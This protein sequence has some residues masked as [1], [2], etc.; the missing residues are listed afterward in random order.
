M[1]STS[2]FQICTNI[3]F[4]KYRNKWKCGRTW[5]DCLD[6]TAE[7]SLKVKKKYLE[8]LYEWEVDAF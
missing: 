6:W 8:R 2:F 1:V 3:L 4:F 5:S 7:I